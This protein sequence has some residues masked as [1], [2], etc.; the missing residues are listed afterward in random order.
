MK[1]VGLLRKTR[2]R[3]VARVERM[4]TCAAA[5]YNLVRMRTLGPWHETESAAACRPCRW[6]DLPPLRGK[7]E[8]GWVLEAFCNCA[9]NV[10]GL[11]TFKSKPG[12]FSSLLD[13]NQSL[14]PIS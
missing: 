11:Y 7:S 14:L 1:T 6:D 8:D 13:S 5:V 4:F 2:Y 3:G 12:F 10:S 9:C